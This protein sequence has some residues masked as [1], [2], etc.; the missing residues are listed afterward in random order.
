[1]TSPSPDDAALTR[2][3]RG[4]GL[5]TAY[6]PIVDLHRLEVTG[7]EALARFD[8]PG[9]GADRRPGPPPDGCAR[10]RAWG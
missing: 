4:E 2:A 3:I 6:Q 7:Y 9:I 8:V 5:R 1:M 10:T